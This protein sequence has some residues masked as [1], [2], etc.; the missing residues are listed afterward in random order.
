MRLRRVET[1]RPGPTTRFGGQPHFPGEPVWPLHPNLGLPLTFLGQIAVPA[2]IAGDGTWLAHIFI[3]LT[4]E[5][6]VG[7]PD[8]NQGWATGAV[9]VHPRGRWWGP[10]DARLT[11]PTCP[12]AWP[13][14]WPSRDPERERLL[15]GPQF[16][17]IVSEVDLVAGADPEV[18]PRDTYFET[19]NDDW[20]KVGGTPLTLQ[21]GEGYFTERGWRF[22]ASFGAEEVGNEMG[23]AAHCS[24]W[25]HPDGRG[26]LAVDSH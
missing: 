15:P 17:F 1:A 5:G 18:W 16:R 19:T 26:A 20:N 24:V 13:D 10:T 3:D 8:A 11:G 22:L 25:V 2:T 21:Q 12:H 7:D 14:E 23:D 9:I 4:P 6:L